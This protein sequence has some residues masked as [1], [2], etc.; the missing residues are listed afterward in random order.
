MKTVLG[1]LTL[2]G[3]DSAR[4]EPNDLSF[5]FAPDDSRDLVVGIQGISYTDETQNTHDLL[6]S[7][8]GI[9]AYVDSTIAEIWLPASAC[10]A[11]E[12]AFGLV[13]DPV[14][15]LYPVN[16]TWHAHMQILNPNVTF[17]LGNTVSGGPT[18]DIILPYAAFDLQASWPKYPSS[19]LYFPLQPAANETQYTLGRTFL[20]EA[21]LI[22]DWE[23]GNF[24]VSQCI[25]PPM[26][27]SNLVPIT[28][29]DN[30]QNGTSHASQPGPLTSPSS[31]TN[32]NNTIGVA[33]GVA[34]GILCLVT[35]VAAVLVF[36]RRK[37]RH[38][39]RYPPPTELADR[40]SYNF[41]KLDPDS[42]SQHALVEAPGSL[43]LKEESESTQLLTPP[44]PSHDKDIHPAF[45]PSPPF[46]T[47]T[48]S[49]L[50]GEGKLSPS[51]TAN[52][53][54]EMYGSPF[55]P[56]ELPAGDQPPLRMPQELVGSNPT[57]NLI[58]LPSATHSSLSSSP[59][60]DSIDDALS[61]LNSS[62][63]PTPPTRM[64]S[65]RGVFNRPAMHR[66]QET[67]ESIP[68]LPSRGSPDARDM[69]HGEY[70]TPV[71][72]VL[73]NPKDFIG[74]SE[75]NRR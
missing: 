19:T 16:S 75:R 3:Y 68:S 73:G 74:R 7:S 67:D 39:A 63:R 1:S 15:K 29:P 31:S 5:D 58:S 14:N 62:V 24:S 23:R 69:G 8:P 44:P 49:E 34:V 22:V 18:I 40:K 6:N 71:S 70:F 57:P 11:F 45:R 27:G 38:I 41:A 53:V 55:V 72:P 12:D 25:W 65:L 50:K 4:F 10:A 9:L 2:G 52:P 64:A 60:M 48:V 13:Y 66:R 43:P 42:E 20:Q 21:Y 36:R 17:T 47:V 54:Q 32:S 33:V 56:F 35:A 26:L 46:A 30:S 51:R 61:S 59:L 37:A 28:S